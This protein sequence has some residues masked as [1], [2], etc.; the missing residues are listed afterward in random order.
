MDADDSTTPP[1]GRRVLL[2]VSAALTVLV[3]GP[4]L[5]PGFAL[6][7]DMVFAPRQYL[8]PESFGL[9]EVLPRSVPA[10]AVV[11]AATSVLPG[12]LVQTL[13]L[14]AAV[15]SAAYGAGRLVPTASVPTRVVAAVAYVWS[16]YF[17]ERL[18]LGHWPLLLTYAC[19]PWIALAALRLRRGQA[20]AGARLVLATAPAV[21][22]APGG[23]LAAGV[24][25]ACA[26]RRKVG[27]VLGVSAVLNAPWWVPSLLRGAETL[28][29]PAGVAAFSARAESW[30][31]AW[32]SVLGLGGVWNAEVVPDSRTGPLAPIF[33]LVTVAVALVGLRRLACRWGRPAWAL[34]VLGAIGFALAVLATMPMGEPLLAW[35]MQ[36]VPG[37]G[38]LRD[39]QRWVAWWALPWALGFALGAE[40]LAEYVR[41]RGRTAV[42]LGAALLPVVVMPDL[43]WAGWGRMEPV[44]YPADWY[45]VREI[46]ADDPAPGAVVTLPLSSFRSFAWNE[47]RTQL[48]PAPRVLPRSTVIDD[49]L[50]VGDAVVA[51]EDPRARHVRS[52]S[53]AENLT[54]AGIGWI[55]VEHGT[56]GRADPALLEDAAEVWSG[57]WL[58]LYRVPGDVT[59]TE[60]PR[61]QVVAVAA[62][63]GLAGGLM[64]G[65][66]L[67]LGL[68]SGRLSR[69]TRRTKE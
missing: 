66:L 26:G 1:H 51:G 65:T 39:G 50:R 22:T 11:A 19:L 57:P 25:L 69:I 49:R 38:L 53:S 6:S 2:A 67:W 48:D 60:I 56:P 45:R 68:P 61:T 5:G 47:H 27:I 42:L 44:D 33:V 52:A 12:D 37:A 32:L 7:Y 41:S 36:H 58:S 13:V 54:E 35:A 28:S 62:A 34:C 55:L 63:N 20:R 40:L 46:L 10:D 18:F 64:I 24:A 9:G 17:A 16:A 14:A 3:L 59:P 15:F 29:D 31:P 23:V 21:L 30:G 4:L 43:A 8:L